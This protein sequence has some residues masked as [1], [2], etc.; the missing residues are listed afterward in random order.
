MEFF[1]C[2]FIGFLLCIIVCFPAD[3]FSKYVGSVGA[4]QGVFSNPYRH[5]VF[6]FSDLKL[7]YHHC[8]LAVPL[9]LQSSSGS[10]N[11][12]FFYAPYHQGLNGNYFFPGSVGGGPEGAFVL[13]LPCDVLGQ[14]HG[15][16]CRIPALSHP[17][18]AQ[19]VSDE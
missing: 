5:V 7:S 12:A 11:W 15:H 19:W 10:A 16:P 4:V 9:W 8:V 13:S 17:L 14:L 2:R 6:R 18:H 1:V 3:V